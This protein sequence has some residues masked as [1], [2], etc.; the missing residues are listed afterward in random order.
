[1]P[2][3][4]RGPGIKQAALL[5]LCSGMVLGATEE[6]PGRNKGGRKQPTQNSACNDVPTHPIR[7]LVLGRPTGD[8]ITLS[9]LDYKDSEATSS[10]GTQ[11]GQ[12]HPQ[13]PTAN[14]G[15][16]KPAEV[17]I[18][19]LQPDTRYFYQF[20]SEFL[21]MRGSHFSK[22]QRPP[23]SPFTFTI[24]ADSHL[25]DR[26]IPE[27]IKVRWPTPWKT[28]PISTSIWATVR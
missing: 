24:I 10:Y 17:L 25:D 26:A 6:K 22:T 4:I 2:F 12:L 18:G 3:I 9:V 28:P 14:S 20:R 27:A 8:S 15:K 23:N 1:M 7:H 13:T 5:V 21:N 11:P 16:A 19:S